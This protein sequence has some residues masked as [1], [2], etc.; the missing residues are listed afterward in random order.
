MV[1]V[2]EYCAGLVRLG[3][4]YAKLDGLRQEVQNNEIGDDAGKEQ[5]RNR[6]GNGIYFE[7]MLLHGE[8]ARLKKEVTPDEEREIFELTFTEEEVAYITTSVLTAS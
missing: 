5:A 1:N 4:L 3:S 2:R 7:Y 8:M 6:Y